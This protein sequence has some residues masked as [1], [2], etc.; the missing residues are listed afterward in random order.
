MTDK[1]KVSSLVGHILRFPKQ[2]FS[3]K[4]IF[5]DN[6]FVKNKYIFVR[7]C[8]KS[9]KGLQSYLH[10]ANSKNKMEMTLQ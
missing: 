1:R 7:N 9:I 5:E 8:I 4:L 2:H 6:N 10:K 3:A